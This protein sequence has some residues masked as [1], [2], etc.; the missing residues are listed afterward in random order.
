LQDRLDIQS[1]LLPISRAIL[2]GPAG[3]EPTETV[4]ARVQA[5]RDRARFRL[6]GTPW[7]TNAEVPGHVLRRDWPVPEARRLLARDLELG[8]LSSRAVDR[9]LKLSWT[10]ADLHHHDRPDEADIT[11]A[12]G[13][14]L[15][16][17][18]GPPLARSA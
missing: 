16:A 10:L 18:V 5:A 13:L 14:R 17:P 11:I 4:R 9:V 7:S 1:E 8:R 12:R 3:G 6:R 2:G 15:G